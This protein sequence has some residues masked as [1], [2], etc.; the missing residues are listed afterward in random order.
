[1]K[2]ILTLMAL[3]SLTI[4][5]LAYTPEPGSP[6]RATICNAM[7]IA[8]AKYYGG[9]LQQDA[10]RGRQFIISNIDVEGDAAIFEGHGENDAY[11]GNRIAAHLACGENGWY[12]VKLQVGEPR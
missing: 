1:M 3:A 5:S 2:T 11:L 10:L 4:A 6:I 12:V 9:A 7:R 8:I